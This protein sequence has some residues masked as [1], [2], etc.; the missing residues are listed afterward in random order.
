MGTV[1]AQ[2]TIATAGRLGPC[3]CCRRSWWCLCW[4]SRATVRCGSSSSSSLLGLS[5]VSDQL[6]LLPCLLLLLLDHLEQQVEL[7]ARQACAVI[8]GAK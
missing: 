1:P 8:Q 4:C 5:L 3:C 2:G 6:G 7:L